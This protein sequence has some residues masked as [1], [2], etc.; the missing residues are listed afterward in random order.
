[1]KKNPQRLKLELGQQGNILLS[2]LDL[3][4]SYQPPKSE[5]DLLPFLDLILIGFLF[6]MLNTQLV[7]TPGISVDLPTA[8]SSV[9]ETTLVTDVMTVNERSGQ[10]MFF[11]QGKIYEYDDLALHAQNIALSERDSGSVLL[12]KMAGTS[13]IQLQS[14]LVAIAKQL[15]Y[16]SVQI[17]VEPD[18]IGTLE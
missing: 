9:L 8:D 16:K 12:I 2:P 11:Y 1:M 18:S 10:Q 3:R 15:G 7:Y 4:V 14:D 17:A 6:F 5:M 13:S